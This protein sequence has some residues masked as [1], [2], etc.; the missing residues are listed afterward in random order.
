VVPLAHTRRSTIDLRIHNLA[1]GDAT[2]DLL[3][4]RHDQDVGVTVLRR[5][6]DVQVLVAK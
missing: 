5:E 4:L 1:V 3:L 2:V 6:G